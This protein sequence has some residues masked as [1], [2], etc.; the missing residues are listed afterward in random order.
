MTAMINSYQ[1]KAVHQYY[2]VDEFSIL[3]S[4]QQLVIN[5]LSQ[6]SQQQASPLSG[7]IIDIG[8]GTGN[9]LKILMEHFAFKQVYGMDLSDEM[10]TIAT[11]KIKELMAICSSATA[12]SQHFAEPV[13]DLL[14]LHF[15]FAY[16]DHKKL[17][18]Q[19][20]QVI[21]SGGLLSICTTTGNSFKSLQQAGTT[22]LGRIVTKLL[23][24]DAQ[25]FMD[26]FLEF[27]PKN[28]NALTDTL[29]AN[30]F[31]VLNVS[32]QRTKVS[33]ATGTD[34]WN[35]LHNA[36]WFVGALHQLKL[37]KPLIFLMFYIAKW[38]RLIPV[39]RGCVEDV[40]EV[41]V[42]TARKI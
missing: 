35:L 7:T 11:T 18:A 28:A 34:A 13:A 31:E 12:L 5:Q 2:D 19:S 36:G 22:M 23:K 40:V 21:K 38:T 17:I 3:A 16:I 32:T 30:G 42:L 29:Q 14:V 10:L 9:M 37:S 26:E 41:V 39:N 15:L 1:D 25:T 20:A 27:M 24:F 8:C 33:C 4:T 6:A